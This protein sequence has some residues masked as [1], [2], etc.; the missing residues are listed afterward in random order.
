MMTLTLNP[1]A[2]KLNVLPVA[3]V[4]VTGTI[5]FGCSGVLLAFWPPVS[6]CRVP[7]DATLLNGSWK[8]SGEAV[9]T[10]FA[11]CAYS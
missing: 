1:G 2:L 8:T 6:C 4:E 10:V 5:K 9:P 7:E 11:T 3:I